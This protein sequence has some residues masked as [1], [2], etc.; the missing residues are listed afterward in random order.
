M[1]V[2]KNTGNAFLFYGDWWEIIKDYPDDT[3]LAI[4]DTIIEYGLYEKLP[5]LEGEAKDVF[6]FIKLNIDRAEE[7]YKKQCAINKINGL[8]GGAPK[9]NKNAEKQPKTTINDNEYKNKNDSP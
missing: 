2:L 1:K 3:R 5:I 6:D 4:W 8:K 9:G 7:N